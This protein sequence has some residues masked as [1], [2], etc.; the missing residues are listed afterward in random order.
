MV[1]SKKGSKE[2]V[3]L[4]LGA[5]AGTHFALEGWSVGARSLRALDLA[6]GAGH[7]E[8][9]RLIEEAEASR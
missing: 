4:L 6:R 7:D 8:C 1:A 3:V 9:A 2:C 5:N